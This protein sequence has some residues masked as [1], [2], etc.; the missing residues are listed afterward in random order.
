MPLLA[1]VFFVLTDND[2]KSGITLQCAILAHIYELA[3][4]DKIKTPLLIDAT[5]PPI[6]TGTVLPG[7]CKAALEDHT[8]SLLARA[9]PHLIS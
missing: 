2:H 5:S 3:S 6:N 8:K 1:D 4:T 7:S 9:F